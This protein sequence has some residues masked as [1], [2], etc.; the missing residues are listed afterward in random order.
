MKS[1]KYSFY[2]VPCLKRD[3]EV[4]H[5]RVDILWWYISHMVIP[6]SSSRRF[7]YLQKV[8][9]LVLILHS[10]AGE[11]RLFSMVRKNKTDSR[12]SLNLHGTLSDL[13]SMKLQYPESTSPCFKFNP[14]GE[15]LAASKRAAR[16]YNN[17]HK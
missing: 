8:A 1:D 5:Y 12:S 6:K 14:D 4:S 7:R 9:E 15:L 17:E 16:E 2:C 11:E 13:L 10:N 3:E